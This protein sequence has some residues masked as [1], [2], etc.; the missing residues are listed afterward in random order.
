MSQTQ[1]VRISDIFRERAAVSFLSSLAFMGIT[2]WY[3]TLPNW[4]EAGPIS[5]AALVTILLSFLL[6]RSARHLNIGLGRAAFGVSWRVGLIWVVLA[7]IVESL[8]SL[9]FNTSVTVNRFPVLFIPTVIVSEVAML[10]GY[11]SRSTEEM[12]LS[13]GSV[14][15]FSRRHIIPLAAFI[16]SCWALALQLQNPPVQPMEK[17]PSSVEG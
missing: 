1:Q 4:V 11:A 6:G 9:E 10:V 14:W 3:W 7:S 17:P 2:A 16:V 12:S 5:L 13:F 8:M 15:T